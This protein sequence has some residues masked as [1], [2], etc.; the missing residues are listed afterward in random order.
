M[1]LTI[2]ALSVLPMG[3]FFSGPDIDVEMFQS[4]VKLSGV[5]DT[6]PLIPLRLAS[7]A[8]A[9]IF[10]P[11][12]LC[13][14]VKHYYWRQR[15]QTLAVLMMILYLSGNLE[16]NPGPQC[17]MQ[18][19]SRSGGWRGSDGLDINVSGLGDVSMKGCMW[20][21]KYEKPLPVLDELR[22]WASVGSDT[23][24]LHSGAQITQ[25]RIEVLIGE[26]WLY[27]LRRTLL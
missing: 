9:P 20:P 1:W 4:S 17:G 3:P 5:N 22:D 12:V 26:V 21:F 15:R 6:V 18:G 23:S 11:R 14:E 27:I 2:L 24:G 7:V 25:G 16:L 10:L 8:R 13:C 19:N